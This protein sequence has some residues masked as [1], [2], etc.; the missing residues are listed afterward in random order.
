VLAT[1]Q[2]DGTAVVLE[3]GLQIAAFFRGEAEQEVV[4]RVALEHAVRTVQQEARQSYF[5]TR[6][7]DAEDL[8]D[9]LFSVY[10]RLPDDLRSELPLKRVIALVPPE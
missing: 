6:L 8:M 5:A 7:W 4:E 1:V 9:E 2:A 3:R 10:E